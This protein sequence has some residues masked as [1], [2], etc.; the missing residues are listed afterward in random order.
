[1]APREPPEAYVRNALPDAYPHSTTP[2]ITIKPQLLSDPSLTTLRELG[3]RVGNK[4]VLHKRLG[5]S[6]QGVLHDHFRSRATEPNKKGWPKQNFWDRIRRST[7]YD[8]SQ[9]NEN[10]AVVV[11][12]EPAYG[13]KVTGATIRPKNSR[14]LA[15]PLRA[16]VY[17][18][19]ARDFFRE[20]TPNTFIYRSKRGKAFVARREGNALRVYYMLLRSAKVPADPKALPPEPSVAAALLEETQ[21]YLEGN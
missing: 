9:T 5:V 11:V 10:Q 21:A 20:D 1:M 6:L 12:G 4:A 13:A 15:I 2:V 14:F 17:G 3:A 16:V 19:R 8:P 7:A 18:V